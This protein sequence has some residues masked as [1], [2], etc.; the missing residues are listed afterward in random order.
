[1]ENQAVCTEGTAKANLTMKGRGTWGART[2]RVEEPNTGRRAMAKHPAEE[3]RT[4]SKERDNTAALLKPVPAPRG[5]ISLPLQGEPTQSRAPSPAA[6]LD[7]ATTR[8]RAKP[9]LQ[10]A[11]TRRSAR[12][13]PSPE[14]SAPSRTGIQEGKFTRLFPLLVA[15]PRPS[16]LPE[17]NSNFVQKRH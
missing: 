4:W 15:F 6:P 17:D 10:P 7:T 5:R 12:Q 1:M 9:R 11:P 13:G 3:L 8:G 14:R 16:F 2:R